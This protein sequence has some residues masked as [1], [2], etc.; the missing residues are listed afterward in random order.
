MSSHLDPLYEAVSC[1]ASLWADADTAGDFTRAEL[2]QANEKLGTIRRLIDA[3]HVEVA[4]GIAHESRAE[5]GPDSLAKQQGFRSTAQLIATTSGI[6]AGDASR[7]VKVGEATAPRRDLLGNPLPA[8]YPAIQRAIAVGDL[9]TTAA[10]LIIALL[11]RARLKTDISRIDEA[12]RLL[13]EA[14]KALSLD[15]VRKLI[16][17]A[18]AWL[19]PD[20]VEPRGDEARA[21]RSLKMFERDGA[22]HVNAVFDIESAAPIRA[23][24]TG[25][26]SSAFNARKDAIDPDAPDAD[27]RSVAMLQADALSAICA[28]AL[29]CDNRA[30][31][32]AGA[33]VIVRVDLKDLTTGTGYGTVD[34]AD[35]PISITAVRR[36]AA[37]GGVIPCVLDS[38]GEILDWGREKRLFTKAQR[39]ALAERDG[40]CAMCGLPP[41]MTK[42]HH[43]AW[44]QRDAG[45]TDLCNGVLLCESCHHRIHDNGW[46]IRIDGSGVASKVWFIPPPYVDPARTPRLGGLARYT[47]AA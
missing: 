39:L 7:L 13:T 9:H 4:A 15:D 29:G 43:I 2:V 6:S 10:S 12:E 45:P 25:W 32:L 37:S 1:I 36:M 30:P 34:G 11:D 24:I 21:R 14:A 17:R 22:L 31:G 40:G 5:L 26:V 16:A 8:R 27:H 28:H 3:L 47:L 20:G 33:T 41:E 38:S 18:E 19:D 44:W 42:A 46:E 35:S 23:A